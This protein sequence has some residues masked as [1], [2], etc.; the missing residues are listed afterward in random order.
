MPEF[1]LKDRDGKEQTYNRD[2]IT[3]PGTNGEKVKFIFPNFAELEITENGEYSVPEGVD[4]Y[5]KVKA[6]VPVP[7]LLEN[8]EVP[9]D[10]SNGDMLVEVPDGYAVKS[11]IIKQ[12]ENLKPENIA[13]GVEISGIVGTLV[14]GGGG[15]DFDDENLKYF[16]FNFDIENKSIILHQILYDVIYAETGSYDVTIPNKLG[17]FDVVI[18]SS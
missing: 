5:T 4:G 8:M 3:V 16:V 11:A 14:S 6:N 7:T 15:F 9:L 17:N 2:V 10:F 1:K 12:P 18:K 13:E